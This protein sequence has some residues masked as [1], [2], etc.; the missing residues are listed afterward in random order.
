MTG[1]KCNWM[2]AIDLSHGSAHQCE[3]TALGR[4]SSTL[5]SQEGAELHDAFE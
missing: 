2:Q 1:R 5:V 4:S 3:R